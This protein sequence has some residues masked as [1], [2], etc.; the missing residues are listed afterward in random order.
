MFSG[1]NLALKR[2]VD[3]GERRVEEQH[4]V[5]ESTLVGEEGLQSFPLVTDVYTLFALRVNVPELVL[6]VLEGG[7]SLGPLIVDFLDDRKHVRVVY[8]GV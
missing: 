5:N 4:G 7:K 8:E 3:R 6:H 2:I 1:R